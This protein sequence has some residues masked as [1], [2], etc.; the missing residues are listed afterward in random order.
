MHALGIMAIF[1]FGKFFVV[2]KHTF[3]HIYKVSCGT[4]NSLK[5]LRRICNSKLLRL[6]GHNY[7]PCWGGLVWGKKSKTDFLSYSNMKCWFVLFW[8]NSSILFLQQ[9]FPWGAVPHHNHGP[10]PQ[11]WNHDYMG[12]METSSAERHERKSPKFASCPVMFHTNKLRYTEGLQQLCINRLCFQKWLE[13]GKAKKK[14]PWAWHHILW[15][16]L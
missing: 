4:F 10:R 9:S 8:D 7:F 3:A 2:L 11:G 13:I 5:F 16:I 14:V 12:V 15:H 1:S 6:N